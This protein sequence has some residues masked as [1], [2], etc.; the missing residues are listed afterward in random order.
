MFGSWVRLDFENR[1][2]VWTLGIEL[3]FGSWVRLGFGNRIDASWPWVRLVLGHRIDV[4]AL[5]K[6]GSL[7]RKDLFVYVVGT[8]SKIL[9]GLSMKVNKVLPK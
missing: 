6:I 3:M 2:D 1:I 7:F 9:T 5:G 4:W 8:S